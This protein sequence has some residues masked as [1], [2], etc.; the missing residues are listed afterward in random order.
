MQ[1]AL[2]A[3]RGVTGPL[4]LFEAERG[5]KAVF[6]YEPAAAG[7]ILGAPSPAENFITRVA[8]KAYPCFAGGAMRGGR[9]HRAAS[10]RR[11]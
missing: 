6:A 2:L 4:D 3:A 10:P 5:L 8:I 1:A 11:R 7:D 9:S